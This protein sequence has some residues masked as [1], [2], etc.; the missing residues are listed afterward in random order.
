MVERLPEEF[1]S[2]AVARAVVSPSGLLLAG[3]GTALAIVG[4]LPLAGAFAVGAACW[5]GRVAVAAL[6]RRTPKAESI[7]PFAVGEPW[8]RFVQDALSAERRFEE[9]VRRTKAGPLHDRLG[10]LGARISDGV[11][12]C[13]RIACQGASLQ[14]GLQQFDIKDIRRELDLVEAEFKGAAEQATASLKST[15]KALQSQVAAYERI[16]SVAQDASDRL[17]VLNAQLD[18]AV[19]R[20][21]ELS[22]SAGTSSDVSV[23]AGDVDSLVND[24]EALRQGL[25]AVD[26]PATG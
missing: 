9:T 14:K 2:P 23:L 26:Q 19:A 24:L 20:A 13:W 18:E 7:D 10:D 11:R 4:G 6:R 16:E 1:R 25:E 21:I 22:L 12:E 15:R 8:R 5:A 17:R 3:A